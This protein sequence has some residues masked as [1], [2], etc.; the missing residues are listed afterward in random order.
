MTDEQKFKAMETTRRCTEC[1]T[2]GAKRELPYGG[3]RD[4]YVCQAC[5]F[6]A[7]YDHD[8]TECGRAVVNGY[9]WR[10]APFSDGTYPKLRENERYGSYFKPE[11]PPPRE[12]PDECPF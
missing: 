8:L 5:R 1:G 10:A 7:W 6:V 3:R 11:P 4:S 9:G 12:N 2:V